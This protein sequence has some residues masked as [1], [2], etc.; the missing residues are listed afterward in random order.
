MVTPRCGTNDRGTKATDTVV[1]LRQ[2]AKPRLIPV[3]RPRRSA[4]RREQHCIICGTLLRSDHAADL[5]CDCHIHT[6]FNPRAV[7]ARDLDERILVLMLRAAG[8]PVALCRALGCDE[9]D[10][11]RS[12]VRDSV[13]RLNASGF[14]RIVGC[15]TAGRKLAQLWRVQRRRVGL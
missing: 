1:K 10:T 6:G 5:V 14:V 15:G 7:S 3:K 13:R 2:P 11:N 9:T 12:A 4:P 8:Q